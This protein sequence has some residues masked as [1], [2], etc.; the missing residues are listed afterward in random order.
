MS[1][2]TSLLLLLAR[3]YFASLSV[4]DGH[5][6][7]AKPSMRGGS[8]GNTL[9]A[10]C[11]HCLGT[12]D[13]P[14]P[15]CG[16]AKILDVLTGPFTT[17]KAGEMFEV[18]IKITAH[19]RGHFI[20]RL[21][22]QQISSSMD[23]PNT[24][25]NEHIL[26]RVRPE[27]VHSDCKVNDP[28]GD[29]EPIDEK[30]PGYWYLPPPGWEVQVA[31]A[32]WEDS[33]AKPYDPNGFVDHPSLIQHN[34]STTAGANYN[35][36]YWIPAGFKCEKC[37]L[38]WAWKSAN[39]C[40][41]HP[42]AYNCYFQHLESLG[43][44]VS[45]WCKGACTYNGQCPDTQGPPTPCGE[46]FANCADV[47]VVD[48]GGTGPLG[49]SPAPPTPPTPPAPEPETTS[50]TP[51]S[52]EPE[53]EPEPEPV[54]T[55]GPEPEPEPEGGSCAAVPGNANGCTDESCQKC[56]TGYKWWPCNV[57][58]ACCDCTGGNSAGQTTTMPPASPTPASPAPS[59]CG[60]CADCLATNGVCYA[61]DSDWCATFKFTWCGASLME[62]VSHAK[63][64]E[65]VKAKRE[66]LL[67][68]K[69]SLLKELEAV[70]L[71]IGKRTK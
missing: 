56:A 35:F 48:E 30:N 49:A 68:K 46:E 59:A 69:A 39:S 44:T 71:K 40:V 14:M 24:C 10:Y 64:A 20:L 43:W 54:P 9:N 65:D 25:L 4:V 42:D 57:D 38:Q 19:H 11:P 61:Q 15:V 63:P 53:P 60:D 31:G 32:D 29:C 8:F 37:T 52:P 47:T 45:E 70:D 67:L 5:G 3:W 27:T 26:Q 55:S 18:E 34:S 50:P 41:P 2:V 13:L 17:L 36:H 51:S 16:K 28:R 21:C 6:F 66:A 33:M 58:P 62:V 7:I 23:D 22:D 12:T 1:N